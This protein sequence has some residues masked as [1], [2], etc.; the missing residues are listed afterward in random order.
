[1]KYVFVCVSY[2]CI[3]FVKEEKKKERERLFQLLK[4]TLVFILDTN[5]ESDT[6]PLLPFLSIPMAY[7]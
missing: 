7:Q 5:P 3:V 4:L 2:D 1:M 6:L